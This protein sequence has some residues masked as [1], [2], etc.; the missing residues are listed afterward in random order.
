MSGTCPSHLG[1]ISIDLRITLGALQVDSALLRKLLVLRLLPLWKPSFRIRDGTGV[2]R[3][4]ILRHLRLSLS[5]HGDVDASTTSHCLNIDIVG[6]FDLSCLGHGFFNQFLDSIS[7]IHFLVFKFRLRKRLLHLV[8]GGEV[9][10]SDKSEV[11]SLEHLVFVSFKRF[12]QH[13]D[14]YILLV[15]LLEILAQSQNGSWVD[16]LGTFDSI[17]HLLSVSEGK[18]KLGRGTKQKIDIAGTGN[19]RGLEALSEIDK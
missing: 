5:L 8:G 17:N 2:L 13:S 12:F 16:L 18:L 19:K 1:H 10:I 15:L 6:L 14:S 7:V 11:T 4:E 3:V 9:H